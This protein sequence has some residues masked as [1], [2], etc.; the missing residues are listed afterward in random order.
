MPA[1]PANRPVSVSAA[2][3]IF[4]MSTPDRRSDSAFEPTATM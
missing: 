2:I 3:W 4:L 1:T